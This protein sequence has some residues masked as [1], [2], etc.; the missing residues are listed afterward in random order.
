[1][2]FKAGVILSPIKKQYAF[3]FT[4]GEEQRVKANS[5]LEGMIKGNQKFSM[6]EESSNLDFEELKNLR[7]LQKDICH[8]F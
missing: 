6:E 8:T 2:T 1:M 3:E 4:F 5:H 7:H